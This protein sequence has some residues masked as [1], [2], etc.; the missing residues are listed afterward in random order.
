MKIALITGASSGLGAEFARQIAKLSGTAGVEEMWLLARREEKLAALAQELPL[1]CKILALDLL[2]SENRAVLAEELART[3]PQILYL[4][5][6]A[7]CGRQGY[8][9][10]Q[11][12][13]FYQQMLAL[14][15]RALLDLSYLTKPYLLPGAKVLQIASV[16]AFLPQ[17]AY[18]VYAA[19]KSFVLAFSRALHREWR[20]EGITVTA[21]CPNLMATEFLDK[22]EL[23]AKNRSIKNLGLE[24]PSQVVKQALKQAA[25]GRDLAISSWI[26]KG[27][28]IASK[29]LPH[30]F[31]LWLE[32]VLGLY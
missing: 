15:N 10:D 5:N 4:V 27:L 26:G 14:N 31:I 32:G 7:G 6:S 2:D 16:A 18:A 20:R 28:Y 24:E 19:S 25:A 22:A 12:A 29:I 3:T 11:E 9:A 13:I 17:P 8:F 21:V 23:G 1:P 30:S